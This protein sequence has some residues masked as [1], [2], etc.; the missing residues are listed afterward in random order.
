MRCILLVLMMLLWG[1]SSEA[2]TVPEPS[3]DHDEDREKYEVPEY[4]EAV[5][6]E[7]EAIVDGDVLFDI[8]AVDEGYVAVSAESDRR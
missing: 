4:A 2:Q 7:A 5:F 1:C 8:S 3:Q 6:H